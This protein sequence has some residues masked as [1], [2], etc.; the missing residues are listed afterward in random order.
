VHCT[1]Q[2]HT[3]DAAAALGATRDSVLS[4]CLRSVMESTPTV[5]MCALRS[6]RQKRCVDVVNCC[7]SVFGVAWWSTAAH[8]TEWCSQV[9]DEATRLLAALKDE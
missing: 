4:L 5:R 6:A 1:S 3:C 7:P 8:V 9:L 2:S